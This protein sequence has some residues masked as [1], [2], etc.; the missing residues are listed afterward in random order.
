M[1]KTFPAII[2]SNQPHRI[3]RGHSWVYCNEIQEIRGKPDDGA[4]ADGNIADVYNLKGK[5][6]A[7]G[8][9]NSK[10][11]ISFRALSRKPVEIDDN[12]WRARFQ[13]AIDHRLARCPGQQSYRIIHSDADFLP[14]LIVDRYADTLVL[15]TTTLGMDL[16]KSLF[17]KL[18]VEML[19]PKSILENNEGS[20]RELEKMP[21]IKGVLFGSDETVVRT[22]IGKAEFIC[23]LFD[24]HKTGFY[25]DQQANYEIVAKFARP[26]MRVLDGFCGLAGFGIHALMAGAGEAVGVESNAESLRRAKESAEISGV[27]A[28]LQLRVENMFDYLRKAQEAK[29]KFD[30]II[31][32]PPSFSRSRKT[33]A[34]ARRGYKEI[35]LRAL[36]MLR[37]GGILATFCCSH[38]V[39]DSMFLEFIMEAAHDAHI[40]L[41]REAVLGSGPDH[42]VI[43]S[44][45]ETEYLKGFVFTVLPE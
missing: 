3:E 2:L 36:K 19:N 7:R 1:T 31:L 15:Q 16:R 30:L 20:S 29:E 35:H 40:L 9:Y 41:R 32:D 13:Q 33:V 10:A 23:D 5:F 24:K 14:G 4:A 39:S 18:L 6:I 34:E 12:F 45:P 8:Y 26:A 27:A 42:P 28:R 17:V 37:P 22:G 44:I 25:L 11:I 38:H 43:P 21:R